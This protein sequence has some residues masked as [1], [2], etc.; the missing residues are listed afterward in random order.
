MT[1]RQQPHSNSRREDTEKRQQTIATYQQ[2][3]T[4]HF[5]HLLIPCGSIAAWFRVAMC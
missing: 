1:A 4:H 3:P 5:V 2:F